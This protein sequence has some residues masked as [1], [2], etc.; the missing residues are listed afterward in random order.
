MCTGTD[1]Q[2]DHDDVT[3]NLEY[4]LSL[5]RDE[6]IERYASYLLDL[7]RAVIGTGV[8]LTDFR[9]FILGLSALKCKEQPK[10]FAGVRAKIKDASSFHDIF[11]IL[12]DDEY[13]RKHKIVEFITINPKL[14]TVPN[15]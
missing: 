11:E 5:L 12:D 13:I 6:I 2:D 3:L 14:K 9:L 7:C 15:S 1:D 4:K 8:S 10:L